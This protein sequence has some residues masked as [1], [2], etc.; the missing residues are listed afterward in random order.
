MLSS[1]VGQKRVKNEKNML[2][3]NM[4]VAR[5]NIARVTKS[6]RRGEPFSPAAHSYQLIV[7][8]FIFRFQLSAK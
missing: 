3:R 1:A 2:T 5:E 8:C 7:G 6:E 4:V